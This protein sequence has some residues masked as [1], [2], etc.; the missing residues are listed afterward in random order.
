LLIL[1]GLPAGTSNYELFKASA[2]S[3]ATSITRIL[4]QRIEQGIGRGARGSGDHCAVILKGSDVSSWIS[5]STNFALLTSATRAQIEMG[6]QISR[7]ISTLKDLAETIRRSFD[8]DKQ[9][10]EYHAETLAEM[11]KESPK[12]EFRYSQ[13]SIER[14]ALNLWMDGYSGPA[15]SK[16]EK[17][18][19]ENDTKI[20]HANTG[21]LEQFIARIAC[22]WGNVP[23][24]DETQRQAYSN[25]RNLIRPKIMPVYQPLTIPREQAKNIIEQI[26]S[27]N[28]RKGYLQYFEEVVILLNANTSANQ[29]EQA[30][31]DLGRIL[32]F[33]S[34]RHDDNGVGPDVLWILPE[35]IGLVI[36]AKSRKK[37]KNALTKEEHGQL[38]VAA[39]WFEKNYPGYS[40]FR[41]SIHPK[42]KATKAA[43][44]GASHALTYENM[45]LLIADIRHFLTELCDSQLP[46]E[47]LVVECEKLLSKF[48]FASKRLAEYYLMPFEEIAESKRS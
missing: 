40:Y 18:I 28:M 42:N 16:I 27:Y 12:D 35:Q 1:D 39:E 41:I 4:A 22:V 3:G 29:F 19:V 46:F 20:D 43:V 15:I 38:L 34:E 48:H 37:E 30:L 5:K 6:I 33:A 31:C 8:R 23:K 44:A 24:A 2:L 14:K 7:E 9:W 13:A 45:D 47:G 36:E 21:W 25:N 32:G 26:K 10:I 11:V 17:F